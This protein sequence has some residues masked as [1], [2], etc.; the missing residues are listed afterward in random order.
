MANNLSDY[1]EAK[2][3]DHSVG[4]TSWTMPTVSVA[5]YT[6]T[7]TDSTAGTEVANS[8][9]YAR[10]V[11]T[12]ADW[13]AASA[14]ANANAADITFTTATGSWGT[15]AGVALTDSSTYGGGNIIWYGALTA[16]KTVD[17]GDTFKFAAGDLTLSLN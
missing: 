2:I 1:A 14:G 4:K 16:S 17:S 12:G 6:A 3:I 9:S 7:P 15:V 11:T 10:K 5:L 8:G 13:S